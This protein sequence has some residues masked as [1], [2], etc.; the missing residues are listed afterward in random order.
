MAA[1]SSRIA[2]DGAVHETFGFASALSCSPVMARAHRHDDVEIVLSLRGT[3]VLDLAGIA[4]GVGPGECAV[5]W[6]GLPHRVIGTEDSDSDGASGTSLAWVTVPLVEVLA[7]PHLPG[8]FTAQLLRGAL[9]RFTGPAT[10][11]LTMASWSRDIGAHPAL[12]AAAAREA[13]GLLIRASH[14]ALSDD[15]PRRLPETGDRARATAMAAWICEHFRQ[16]ISVAR[17]AAVAHVHPS[18]AAAVF[19]RQLGVTI[20]DYLAQCRTAE[21]QRLLIAT[22]ATTSEVAALSGFGSTSRLYARF[23]EEVGMPPGA[24]RRSLRST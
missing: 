13:E 24:Y 2:A 12:T 9:L 20:G 8:T 16:P 18:T 10:L 14:L 17:V 19:R 23:A 11:D 1:H 7:S 21:A 4:Y 3:T 5:L 22:D 6:A 15:R